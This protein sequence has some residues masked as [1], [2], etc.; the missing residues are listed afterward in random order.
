M[1][2]V[3]AYRSSITWHQGSRRRSRVRCTDTARHEAQD[4]QVKKHSEL[5]TMSAIRYYGTC[6][7]RRQ[8]IGGFG[9]V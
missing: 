2:D 7:H 1:R 3:C 5:N 4:Q 6:R 9:R 8:L